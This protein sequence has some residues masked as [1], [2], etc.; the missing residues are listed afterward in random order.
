ME[1]VDEYV[2]VLGNE[3]KKRELNLQE[4]LITHW[5]PDHSEGVQPI[6]KS[7]TKSA[8]KVSKHKLEGRPEH[9]IETNYNYIKDGDTIETEGATI[10]AVYTPGHT[11]D[12]LSFYLKEEN[13]LF[14]GTCALKTV[15]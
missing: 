5:H 13:A 15:N 4:I 7:I 11:T 3:L 14:S 8:V 6:F 2:K 1:N 10:Q 12:H 9:D